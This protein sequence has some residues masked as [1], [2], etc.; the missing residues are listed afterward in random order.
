[1]R[2]KLLVGQAVPCAPSAW[3]AKPFAG[4]GAHRVAR[5]T[6]AGGK[7]LTFQLIASLLLLAGFL[8]ADAQSLLLKN[9]TVH[10]VSGETL[11]PGEVLIRD[12]KIAGVGK[13]VSP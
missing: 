7:P 11:S 8:S 2:T 10:T 3:R 13:T 5:P 4:S 9:A 1:M 6:S 12:G